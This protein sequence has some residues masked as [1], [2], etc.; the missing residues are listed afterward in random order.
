MLYEMF[1]LEWKSMHQWKIIS[2]KHMSLD[3]VH[4]CV[5]SAAFVNIS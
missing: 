4:I 3:F 5:S 2:D 1:H